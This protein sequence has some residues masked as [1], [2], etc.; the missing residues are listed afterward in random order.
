MIIDGDK[1]DM[2]CAA[3][4]QKKTTIRAVRMSH[5][6]KVTTPEGVMIGKAGDYLALGVMGDRYPIDKIIFRQTYEPVLNDDQRRIEFQEQLKEKE[7]KS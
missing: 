1:Y 5:E 7:N 2:G 4:Y 6:F 3:E